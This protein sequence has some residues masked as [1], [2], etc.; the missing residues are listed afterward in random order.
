MDKL[1]GMRC[2][3]QQYLDYAKYRENKKDCEWRGCL[4]YGRIAE[5]QMVL[6]MFGL[7]FP[8]AHY[9]FTSPVFGCPGSCAKTFAMRFCHTDWVHLSEG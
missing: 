9:Y 8:S 4:S 2:H 3:S 7:F 1:I 5:Q 6:A